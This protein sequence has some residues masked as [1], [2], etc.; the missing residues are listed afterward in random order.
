M[1]DMSPDNSWEASRAQ[2]LSLFTPY[3]PPWIAKFP[4]QL[5]QTIAFVI[6]TS[7]IRYQ[8][9]LKICQ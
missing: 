5:P 4:Y 3:N 7:H 9:D 6:I 8:Y 2:V 1:T